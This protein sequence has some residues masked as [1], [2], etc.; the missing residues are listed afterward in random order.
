M[1][2]NELKAS[3]HPHNLYIQILAETGLIGSILF[4]TSIIIIILKK[5]K[6][7]INKKKKFDQNFAFFIILIIF[8]L[9]IPTGNVF[10][11][12]HGVFFWTYLLM[13]I[14]LKKVK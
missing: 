2:L 12:S 9:P 3:T 6:N 10:G 7:F 14:N 4:F 1:S 8:L 13:N 11:T 5:I